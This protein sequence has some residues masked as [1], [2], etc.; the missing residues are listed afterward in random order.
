MSFAACRPARTSR[1]SF[2]LGRPGPYRGKV[3]VHAGRESRPVLAC[4]TH[5]TDG[6]RPLAFTPMEPDREQAHIPAEQ[7]P[8]REDPRLPAAYAYSRGPCDPRRTPPQGSRAAVGL[9]FSARM[10]PAAARMRRHEEFTLAVRRGRRVRRSSIVV[11][12]LAAPGAG[13]LA[14]LPPPRVGFV[15]GRSVGGSVDRHRVVR[16]LR[17]IVRDRLSRLPCGSRLVVRALPSAAE[18]T[19]AELAEEFDAALDRVLRT[20]P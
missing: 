20:P 18:R 8:P 4:L 14:A 6:R 16:K 3:C 11:H 17:H 10:L 19:S 2:D 12:Y 9:T 7:P 13:S 1:G 5:R 15:V